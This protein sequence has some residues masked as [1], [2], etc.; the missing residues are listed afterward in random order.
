MTNF[1]KKENSNDALHSKVK[2]VVPLSEQIKQFSIVYRNLVAAIGKPET[3]KFLS[4]SLFFIS[5]GNNDIFGYYHSGSNIPKQVFIS[6][7]GLAYE[8]YLRVRIP[9]LHIVLI[10][11]S[12]SPVLGTKLAL[13]SRCY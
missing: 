11:T 13:F 6:T 9:F 2:N 8:K 12:S 10:I 1:E 7:L 4:K 5:T 3:E